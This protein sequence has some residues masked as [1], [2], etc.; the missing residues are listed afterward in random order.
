MK[1]NE[2]KWRL[3]HFYVR[4]DGRKRARNIEGVQSRSGFYLDFRLCHVYTDQREIG[5][6]YD[7]NVLRVGKME[8]LLISTGVLGPLFCWA[9]TLRNIL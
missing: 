5:A 8:V 1:Q 4:S 6:I 2:I 7:E 3:C 9:D